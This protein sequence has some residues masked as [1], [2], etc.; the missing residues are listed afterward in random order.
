MLYLVSTPIGNLKDITLRALEVL[1]QVDYIA[2]EDTR[3]SRVLLSHYNI[4]KPLISYHEH[5]EKSRGIEIISLLQDGKN[6]ALITDA[7]T[8]C[9]SDPGAVIVRIAREYD[10]KIESVIGASAIT[11]AVSLAGIDTG[12]AFI[13]FLPDKIKTRQEKLEKYKDIDIHLVIYAS[14]HSIN[15]DIKTLY[16]VYGDRDIYIIKELTKIYESVI[17]TKLENLEIDNPRGEYVLIVSPQERQ[18][19]PLNELSIEDHVIYLMDNENLSKK[20]AI[21]QVAQARGLNKNAVYTKVLDLQKN[22]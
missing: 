7:G 22:E 18:V 19:N 17:V 2:C 6:V 14:P 10:I 4:H 1:E 16:K 3:H 13:G 9:I 12:F 11:S 15:K 20:E 5:N 8:P 21:K